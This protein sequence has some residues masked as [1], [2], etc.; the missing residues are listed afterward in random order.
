MKCVWNEDKDEAGI[1]EPAHQAP[2]GLFNRLLGL[3]GLQAECGPV[4]F[5][6]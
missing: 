4:R 2:R 6:F 3:K 5:A 1:S